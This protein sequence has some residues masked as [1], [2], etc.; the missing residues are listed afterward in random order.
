MSIEA[1]HRLLLI[2]RIIPALKI[3]NGSALFND[4]CVRERPEW[5]KT[6]ERM[7]VE[8]RNIGSEGLIAGEMRLLLMF[9]TA[10]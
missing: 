6:N 10:D 1:A 5:R 7:N 2:S 8:K 3:G 4:E 9:I